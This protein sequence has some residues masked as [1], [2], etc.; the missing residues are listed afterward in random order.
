MGFP[1]WW[2]AF[3]FK[4]LSLSLFHRLRLVGRF[5]ALSA[6]VTPLTRAITTLPGM[7]DLLPIGSFFTPSSLPDISSPFPT[8]FHVLIRMNSRP[9]DNTKRH[10]QITTISTTTPSSLRH[11]QQLLPTPITPN[12]HGI[13]QRLRL[14]I[15]FFLRF[16]FVTTILFA[17]F[18]HKHT[19]ITPN[20]HG[21]AQRLRLRIR[22]FLCFIFVTTILS[23]HF[24]HK[25]TLGSL[26]TT[27]LF[28]QRTS[29]MPVKRQIVKH[30][31]KNNNPI[32]P[33]PHEVETITTFH[34]FQF[35]THEGSPLYF[36]TLRALHPMHPLQVG[37][38][39]ETDDG[40][41]ETDHL[42]AQGIANILST[43]FQHHLDNRF[44]E[45]EYIALQLVQINQRPYKELSAKERH[46]PKKNI[47]G[48]TYFTLIFRQ[49]PS[50]TDAIDTT[51]VLDQLR[52][53]VWTDWLHNDATELRRRL[54]LNKLTSPLQAD[55]IVPVTPP[56]PSPW[57]PFLD[58]YLPACN[59]QTDRSGGLLSGFP[60][61]IDYMNNRRFFVY[62]ADQ[63]HTIL[64]PYLPPTMQDATIFPNL[65]GIRKGKFTTSA[66]LHTT[67]DVTYVA[68]STPEM[69]TNLYLAQHR[70]FRAQKK[71]AIELYGLTLRIIP[72]PGTNDEGIQTRTK[73]H[74]SCEAIAKQFARF[75]TLPIPYE[76][77]PEPV[78]NDTMTRILQT[79]YVE[80]CIPYFHNETNPEPDHYVLF[81]LSNYE[82]L[83]ITVP[84]LYRTLKDFP[85]HVVKLPPPNRR[86]PTETGQLTL[87][88]P[89]QEFITDDLA[90]LSNLA[91]MDSPASP[92]CTTITDATTTDNG[93][94]PPIPNQITTSK[95]T[96]HSSGST[97]QPAKQK[98]KSNNQSTDHMEVDP[99]QE[100]E[101]DSTT[102]GNQHETPSQSP[103]AEFI[104]DDQYKFN[105]AHSQAT[106]LEVIDALA[107]AKG[108]SKENY[109][110]TLDYINNHAQVNIDHL[111][112]LA[113]AHRRAHNDS[114]KAPPTHPT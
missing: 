111:K 99:H 54:K 29:T 21:I 98:A 16:I 97:V 50:I 2:L 44:N 86:S 39:H 52:T 78:D 25:N 80:A 94:P 107:I 110:Q 28:Q 82:T 4:S 17:H 101:S 67:S 36:L 112:R 5:S 12:G 68:A 30:K 84:S 96:H 23:A 18:H 92:Q 47:K 73:F 62:L 103:P 90:F 37:I 102:F 41:I 13:A 106:R 88:Q 51:L 69:F 31:D 22:S 61:T 89:L 70:Y 93:T 56:S 81:I 46:G 26:P 74:D 42:T 104:P 45:D 1:P 34:N 27:L 75:L 10:T 9:P 6:A 33:K 40:Y 108:R 53:I 11:Q 43:T 63:I 24:Q 7:N 85:P 59:H 109:K 72:M 105:L 8:S 19:P 32:T 3:F 35:D 49:N 64:H 48:Q 87:A 79:T 95:R 60:T 71:T 14:R 55:E 114:S 100:S 20:E 83:Y 57:I 77:F 65:I 38:A 58:L 76:L 91:T 66:P 113:T 15:R